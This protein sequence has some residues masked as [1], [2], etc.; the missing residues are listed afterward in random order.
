MTPRADARP[1]M[2][3]EAGH[4]LDLLIAERVMGWTRGDRYGNGN[5]EWLRAEDAGKTWRLTWDQTPRFS[6]NM[7][8]AWL[9]VT[10]L[11]ADGYW[12]AVEPSG[13]APDLGGWDLE[14]WLATIVGPRDVDYSERRAGNRVAATAPLAICNAALKAFAHSELAGAPHGAPTPETRT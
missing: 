5:G 3:I 9:V 4:K 13:Y 14:G 6:T 2:T 1:P 12:V 7:A 8:D 10:K 11:R